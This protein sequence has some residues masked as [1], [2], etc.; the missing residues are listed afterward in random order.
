M[1]PGEVSGLSIQHRWDAG[2][3]ER[4][5]DGQDLPARPAP[6]IPSAIPPPLPLRV[7]AGFVILSN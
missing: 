1:T 6:R 4:I 3:F 5:D 2:P 7:P